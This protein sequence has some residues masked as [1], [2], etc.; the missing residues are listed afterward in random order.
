MRS[1]SAIGMLHA[2]ARLKERWR[3]ALLVAAFCAQLA[4]ACGGSSAADRDVDPLAADAGPASS[5]PEPVDAGAEASC[6]SA[7]GV[8]EGNAACDLIGGCGCAPGETCRLD[9]DAE[10]LAACGPLGADARGEY[11]ACSDNSQCPAQYSCISSVCK[12]HCRAPDDCG[13]EG[14]RCVGVTGGGEALSGAGYCPADCDVVSPQSPRAGLGACGPGLQ[15]VPAGGG[16]DCVALVFAGVEGDFCSSPADCAAGLRCSAAGRCERWCRV[17][18]DECGPALQCVALDATGAISAGD[19]GSCACVPPAGAACDIAFGCGCDE[20]QTCGYTGS[21]VGC[22]SLSANTV[23][24]YELCAG[25]RECP[26]LHSCIGSICQKQ[27]NTDADCDGQGAACVPVRAWDTGEPL[28]GFNFCRSNCDP[29]SPQ[30]PAE[31]FRACGDGQACFPEQGVGVCFSAG[32]ALGEGEPCEES[33]CAPG[34]FCSGLGYCTRWCEVGGSTCAPGLECEG[35]GPDYMSGQR[36]LGRCACRPSDGSQCDPS[37]DCGCELGTT[38]DYFIEGRTFVCRRLDPSPVAPHGNCSSDADCSALHGCFSG[39]CKRLCASS[40]DCTVVGSV[41]RAANF[42]GTEFPGWNFCTIPCDP[43]APNI[44]TDGYESCGSGNQCFAVSE[45]P[46]CFAS[47]GTQPEGFPCSSASD[48]QQGFFCGFGGSCQRWCAV[49]ET[50][51]G[52]DAR[53]VGFEPALGYAGHEYGRCLCAPTNGAACDPATDCGCDPGATCRALDEPD[54]FGCFSVV[55]ASVEPYASCS[56]DSQ[57]PALHS[58]IHGACK[59]HCDSLDDC[60][61]EA[62]SCIS[63]EPSAGA[64]GYCAHDCDPVSP[65]ASVVGLPACGSDAQCFPFE[66][67]FDCA[68]A[69]AGNVGDPCGAVDD[70][71]PGSFC[72]DLLQCQAWC[73]VGAGECPAGSTCFPFSGVSSEVAEGFGLCTSCSDACGAPNGICE[74]GGPSSAD[75]LCEPGTDCTDCGVF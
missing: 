9:A 50:D 28:V 65:T 49:G 36:E 16:T 3:L 27:C 35:F 61:G 13:W 26:A 66:S 55:A 7:G 39:M 34:L 45:G 40:D 44:A 15:C 21:G 29:L 8:V 30:N 52:E 37:T 57:C 68:R 24:A 47:A 14:A 71:A 5:P 56:V 31:G 75:A 42:D 58:C 2:S 72:S 23:G 67:G 48:C 25:D 63:L 17:D 22:R 51:C 60:S 4:S 54:T 20:G 69:G 62:T 11:A 73:H 38:C 46:D 6:A 59:K 74:D 32:A 1:T 12:K 43:V 70:C 33:V 18:S 10:L 19:L 53:C 41:C 64:L